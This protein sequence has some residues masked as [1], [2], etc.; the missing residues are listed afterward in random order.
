MLE[1]LRTIL[2]QKGFIESSEGQFKK[3]FINKYGEIVSKSEVYLVGKKGL[4]VIDML[5]DV[6]GCIV[7]SSEDRYIIRQIEDLYD[8]LK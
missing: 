7:L 6:D 2:L 3:S 4:V 5:L 1:T 8:I